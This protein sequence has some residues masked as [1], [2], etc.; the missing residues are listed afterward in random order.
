MFLESL[1]HL[2]VAHVVA[3]GIE[4]QQTIETDALDRGNERT[5][6][7][8]RL[9]TATGTDTN[10]GQGAVLGF[11]LTGVVVDICQCVEL[12][13]NDVDVVTADT[14]TLSGDALAFVHTGNG[15]ELTGRNLVLYAVEVGSNGV[16]ATRV[17][18]EDNLVCQKLGLQM[19]VET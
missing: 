4:V 1:F 7:S 8:E 11:L 3:A 16:H 5:G 18:N 10:H 15:V 19:K 12:V 9:Q 2:Q 17:T 13:D 14:V 6:G